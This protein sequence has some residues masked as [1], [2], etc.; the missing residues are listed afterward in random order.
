MRK[1]A[2]QIRKSAAEAK[3]H[4]P[5]ALA[6]LS[7]EFQARLLAEPQYVA[8]Y[9]PI[10]TEIDP[11]PLMMAL[12]LAGHRL[13]LP[14]TPEPGLPLTFHA[15]SGAAEELIEGPYNTYQPDPNLPVI[16]PD[17]VLAPLLAFDAG[18]WRLGYG[19][20][21]Y[22]RTLAKFEADGH[23]AQLI[24]LAFAEQQVESVPTGRYDR[25]L[26]GIFTPDGLVL[27]EINL[28]H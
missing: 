4:A 9:W 16:Q 21:F 11:R 12:Q 25:Q 3:P 1:I 22:D 15:W 13:C 27:A 6:D 2:A 23:K 5:D 20:G 18:C 7:A 24:G 19:G 10:K 14:V 28:N 8:G 26:N 17:L